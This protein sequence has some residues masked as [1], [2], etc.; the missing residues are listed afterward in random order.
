MVLASENIPRRGWTAPLRTAA[1]LTL[2]SPQN[3]GDGR[4]C[5]Y[6]AQPSICL[7]LLQSYTQ[8]KIISPSIITI[9]LV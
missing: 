5:P 3:H 4:H 6:K 7:A 1:L 8:L 9:N 2:D